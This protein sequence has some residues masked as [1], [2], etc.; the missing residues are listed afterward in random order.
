MI[1]TGGSRG[2]GLQIVEALGEFGAEVILMSRKQA[3][4]REGLSPNKPLSS[5]VVR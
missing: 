4:L 1:V 5:I 3:E 2:L